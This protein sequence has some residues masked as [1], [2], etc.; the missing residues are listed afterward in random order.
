MERPFDYPGSS[1][2]VPT[3]EIH[4][5][6]RIV[7][8]LI[9]VAL[10]VANHLDDELPGNVAMAVADAYEELGTDEDHEALENIA[11]AALTRDGAKEAA[12][13]AVHMFHDTNFECSVCSQSL[14][15]VEEIDRDEDGP[16]YRGECPH[17][18]HTLCQVTPNGD[19]NAA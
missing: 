18:G 3:R 15:D 4:E 7:E 10:N 13:R 8:S 5:G 1:Q 6:R 17:H 19:E 2:G 16:I 11:I 14:T 12:P 9:V